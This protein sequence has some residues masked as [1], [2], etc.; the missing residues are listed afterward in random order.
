M[1]GMLVIGGFSPERLSDAMGIMQECDM[2]AILFEGMAKNVHRELQEV[3]DEHYV[4]GAINKH[5]YPGDVANRLQALGFNLLDFARQPLDAELWP[6][7]THQHTS[8][9]FVEKNR[10]IDWHTDVVRTGEEH[11][12]YLPYGFSFS[13][14][15]AGRAL[16]E[17]A[18]D[19]TRVQV[20]ARTLSRH[21]VNVLA[22]AAHVESIGNA[23]TL[24]GWL[25]P[26][27]VVCWRQPVPHRVTVIDST[28]HAI[29]M[30]QE[31]YVSA[32]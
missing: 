26:G 7:D 29:V 12:L 10:G 2:D 20:P 14:N 13:L 19:R 6:D 22:T 17:V 23:N 18:E 8:I 24:E 5:S 32:D 30:I 1:S 3:Y 31:D 15:L 28:R 25:N 16:F 21:Q 9:E 11:E 4:D 27:D